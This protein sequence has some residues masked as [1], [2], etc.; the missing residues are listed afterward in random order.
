MTFTWKDKPN[1]QCVR[2]VKDTTVLFDKLGLVVH[3]EKTVFIPTQ[4]LKILGFVLNSVT[5]T[6]QL[7]REKATGL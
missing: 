1:D 6:L 2:N 3:P 4:V 7:T 5:M